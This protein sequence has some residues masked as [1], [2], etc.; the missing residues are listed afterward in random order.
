MTEKN[1]LQDSI[2]AKTASVEYYIQLLN[3]HQSDMLDELYAPNAVVEDPYGTEGYCGIEAIKAFYNKAFEAN[4]AARL[5]GPVRVAGDS[6]AFEFEVNFNGMVME[7]IDVFQFN[8]SGK[9]ISMK[10]YWSEANI[11]QPF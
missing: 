4:I 6:A 8:D 1:K 3:A 2:A 9:V 11:Q 10:A 7:I 5:T